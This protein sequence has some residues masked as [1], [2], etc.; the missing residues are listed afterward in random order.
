MFN[1][2]KQKIVRCEKNQCSHNRSGLCLR[3]EILINFLG[4]CC[5]DDSY[6]KEFINKGEEN[7]DNGQI[8]QWS[9]K[10]P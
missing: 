5:Y 7:E 3:D 2:L 9:N 1:N 10:I 8:Q 4:K 6:I